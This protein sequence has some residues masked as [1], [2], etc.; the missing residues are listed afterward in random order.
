MHTYIYIYTHIYIYLC[1]LILRSHTGKSF[2]LNRILLGKN[3]GFSVG[4]TVNA[5]TKG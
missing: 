2:L 3:N 1:K 5:C 4:S